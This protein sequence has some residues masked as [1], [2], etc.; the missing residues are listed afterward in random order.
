MSSTTAASR[1]FPLLRCPDR[2]LAACQPASSSFGT[3]DAAAELDDELE[4]WRTRP[5]GAMTYLILD[6]RY[7]K[8]RHGGTVV[9]CAILTAIGVLPDGKRSVLGTSCS[10]SEAR[11]AEFSRRPQPVRI[12]PAPRPSER[13]ARAGKPHSSAGASSTHAW[14]SWPNLAHASAA[15]VNG[16]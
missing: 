10:L 16:A 15:A 7:E 11:A 12:R 8:V 4:A 13:A 2:L 5:L 3:V 1:P 14:R 6:A 9:D